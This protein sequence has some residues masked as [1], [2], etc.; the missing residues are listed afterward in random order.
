M[1]INPQEIIKQL[2]NEIARLNVDNAVLR[3]AL[4]QAQEQGNG[5][6]KKAGSDTF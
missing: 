6:E 4:A 5:D 1:E 2:S 3:A